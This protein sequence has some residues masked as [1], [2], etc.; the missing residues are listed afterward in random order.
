MH[1][2]ATK[3]VKYFCVTREYYLPF[4]SFVSCWKLLKPLTMQCSSCS[5]NTHVTPVVPLIVLW[6]PS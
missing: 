5:T 1:K 2:I 6:F 3:F 4:C